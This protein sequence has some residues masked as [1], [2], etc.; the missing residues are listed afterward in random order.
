MFSSIEISPYVRFFLQG[1]AG[2]VPPHEACAL[3]R[4][5]SPS[6]TF[7][8]AVLNVLF[9]RA[10]N[11][12]LGASVPLIVNVVNPGL[13]S[14]ELMRNASAATIVIGTIMHKTIAF[15]PEVG[16]RRLVWG[17]V[18]SPENPDALRG[19]YINQ[20]A[21]EEPSDFVISAE[22]KKF[23]DH[24]VRGHLMEAREACRKS[25]SDTGK[26]TRVMHEQPSAHGVQVHVGGRQD[27]R[28][29]K[30]RSCLAR[31]RATR[32]ARRRRQRW[33]S[34]R[35]AAGA[36]PGDV[37]LQRRQSLRL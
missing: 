34:H 36:A 25:N 27:G 28:P 9:V 17:A 15:T 29:G 22:G 14:S 5:L 16:S 37:S 31:Q 21:T 13:C 20:C 2:Q 26:I 4:L 24:S 35:T 19:E 32:R 23:Q 33:S 10:L 3:P 7:F 18:G 1:H 8:I 11:E 12:R 6:I 30:T